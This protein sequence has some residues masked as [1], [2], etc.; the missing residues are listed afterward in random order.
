MAEALKNEINM[1]ASTPHFQLHTQ[2]E[3]RPRFRIEMANVSL[4]EGRTQ[5]GILSNG[6]QQIIWNDNTNAFLKSFHGFIHLRP[7]KIASSLKFL[8]L[9]ACLIYATLLNFID[10]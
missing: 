8:A 3:D 1:C 2:T 9:V 7:D 4:L 5:Q 10:A 6:L